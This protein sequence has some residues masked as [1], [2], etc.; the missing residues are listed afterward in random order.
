MSSA[1]GYFDGSLEEEREKEEEEGELYTL[2]NVGRDADP[3]QIRT[4]YRR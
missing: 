2:L 1:G 3:E 4:A